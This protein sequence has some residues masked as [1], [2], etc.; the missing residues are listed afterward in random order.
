MISPANTM[1]LKAAKT[2]ALMT[3]IPIMTIRT[4]IK[5]TNLVPFREMIRLALNRPIN[6]P[7]ASPKII[8]PI[9]DVE[10]FSV[11]LTS[12]VREIQDE[13]ASP[14]R[15]KNNKKGKVSIFE[16]PVYS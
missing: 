15:R 10:A 8:N 16:C 3:N 9:I 7:H 4:L 14:G 11:S 5:A 13:K 12:G 2:P 6:E 1:L